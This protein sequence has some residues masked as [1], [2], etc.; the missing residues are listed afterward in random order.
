[1]TSKIAVEFGLDEVFIEILDHSN[2]FLQALYLSGLF[3]PPPL[4]AGLAL[5]G[6]CRMRFIEGAPKALPEEIKALGQDMV[7]KGW[8][9]GC[10]HKAVAGARIAL[11]EGVRRLKALDKAGPDKEA[12]SKAEARLAVDFGSTSLHYS[13]VT[14]AGW[15]APKVVVN[16]QMGAGS[17]I[18]SRLA[19]AQRGGAETLASLSRDALSR[20]AAS[21]ADTGEPV[22]EICLAAN[23]S[24]T[25]LLLGKDLSG[26]AAAPYHL[27]YRGGVTEH[28]PCLPPVWVAPLMG[29]FMG[30]D[31]SAGYAHLAFERQAEYPFMLA[32]MGTNGEFVLAL[33]PDEALAASLPLG[34]AL[35]GI[36]MSCGS[37]ARPGIIT[38]F[39]LTSDGLVPQMF[40]TAHPT[41]GLTSMPQGLSGTAYLSLAGHLLRQGLMQT[42]GLFSPSPKAVSP[43]AGRLARALMNKGDG[44][45]FYLSDSL[46]MTGQD[47]E[48]LLKIKGAFSLAL[49]LL[50]AEAGLNFAGLKKL[51][52]AG[53]LGSHID[54]SALEGLG[55]IPMGGASKTVP[56]G[57]SSLAGAELLCREP[58]LRQPL[59]DWAAKLRVL[60]LTD[61]GDFQARYT[62]EMKFSF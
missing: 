40:G 32:D 56:I 23:P 42:D 38:N 28:L 19:H 47:V 11:P 25:Y 50:L 3:E 43:L 60:S 21:A 41:R 49:K 59:V 29:P 20:M 39:A 54:I 35:E 8:R 34:P 46:Y 36:G 10:R 37:E 44:N 9:L 22:G 15:S 13:L 55:F 17:D 30:G 4:C 58:A 31:L 57:N 61:A 14:T 27:D 18:I 2:T 26:L 12:Y 53:A 24:M 48:E 51:Y 7:D 5:C 16:P 45:A 1:M 52:L 62:D 33:G 6:R